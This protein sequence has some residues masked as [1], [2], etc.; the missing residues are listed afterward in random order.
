MLRFVK[1]QKTNKMQIL[2]FLFANILAPPN[3]VTMKTKSSLIHIP[4][5]EL[6]FDSLSLAEQ[7][8]ILNAQQ[9]CSKAYAP[10]SRFYVGVAICLE[11]GSIIQGANQENASFP[12][13]LCAE[14]VALSVC[15]AQHTSKKITHITVAARRAE[16]DKHYLPISPCGICRQS[17]LEV[18][19]QQAQHIQLLLPK[20]ADTF[21]R[22]S[23]VSYLLPFQFDQ[24]HL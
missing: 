6:T 21:Y 10:Y 20:Q 12:A 22:I 5:E 1:I 23:S 7:V 19:V 13:G 2:K 11:D 18:E 8:M 17:L 16:D 14:R 4:F 3:E 24:S 15:Q 9:A